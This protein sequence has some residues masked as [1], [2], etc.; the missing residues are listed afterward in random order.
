MTKDN[1]LGDS[2]PPRKNVK[3]GELKHG[4]SH[5]SNEWHGMSPST[6][7]T[8]QKYVEMEP[9]AGH[10]S[11][12]WV[13]QNA[14]N[15]PASDKWHEM[16]HEGRIDP[17]SMQHSDGDRKEAPMVKQSKSNMDNKVE[18]STQHNEFGSTREI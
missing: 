15:S 11:D 8:S 14:G 10:T 9:S 3:W 13:E 6:E 12:K 5:L 1:R 2:F 7:H 16:K 17:Y 18:R 4:E